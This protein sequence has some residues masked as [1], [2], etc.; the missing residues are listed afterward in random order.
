MR[1]NRKIMILFPIII[2]ILLLF[3]FFINKIQGNKINGINKNKNVTKKEQLDEKD[4]KTNVGN[5]T[6]VK[7]GSEETKTD[8][9]SKDTKGQVKGKA[10][11]NTNNQ[12]GVTVFVKAANFGSTVEVLVDNSSFSTNYKY[13]Q[14]FLGKKP[15]SN[16]ESIEKSE[17][18]IFPAVESGSEVV[19][20]LLD[21]NKKIVKVLN[22]KLNEKK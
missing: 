20:K 12:E 16:I 11:D 9:G 8:T 6:N 10:E 1:N 17:T 21:E 7:G 15:I 18:T 22:I 2:L 14:F 4:G 3:I 5:G 13:Y 19:L